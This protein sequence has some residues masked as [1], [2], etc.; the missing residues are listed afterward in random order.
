VI[1]PTIFGPLAGGTEVGWYASNGN[2]W[3]VVQLI[4]SE[5]YTYTVLTGD[6]IVPNTASG[7]SSC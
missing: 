4:D 3:G 7:A 6:Q 5:T 1:Y 2:S